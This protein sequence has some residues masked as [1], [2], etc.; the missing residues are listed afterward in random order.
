M[1]DFEKLEK[2]LEE[3]RQDSRL[4]LV[5]GIKDKRSLENF[6]IKNIRTIRGPLSAVAENLPREAILLTDYDKRGKTTLKRM[7]ELCENEGIRADTDYWKKLRQTARLTKIE[8][9][10]KK[11]E[12]LRK[13]HEGVNN[14]KNLHRHGKIRCLCRR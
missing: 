1:D 11:Y 2:T 5:E 12:E 9:L 10:E 7:Q 3:L 8:E 6:G 14:G 4:K 13:E